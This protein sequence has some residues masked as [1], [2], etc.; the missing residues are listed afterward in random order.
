MTH[1]TRVKNGVHGLLKGAAA[2]LVG[3]VFACALLL[4][5]TNAAPQHESRVLFISSYSLAFPAVPEQIEGLRAALPDSASLDYLFMDTKAL[6]DEAS[7]AQF[8]EVCRNKLLKSGPYDV[9]VLGDDAALQFAHAHEHTLFEDVPLVFEGVNNIELAR[10]AVRSPLITGVS[11]EPQYEENIR[12]ALR[13]YPAAKNIVAIVDSTETGVGEQA[14]FM[15]QAEKFPQL[16]FSVLNSSL[17]TQSAFCTA[18]SSIRSDTLL[19]SFS[20]NDN[21]SGK[22]YSLAEQMSMIR[23]FTHVPVFRLSSTGMGE[24]YLGGKM[25][26]FVELG[27]LAGVLAT[28]ILNGADP[29][30]LPLITQAPAKFVYDYA[31]L[32][33]YGIQKSDVA[34]NAVF[35]NLPVSFWSQYRPVIVPGLLILLAFTGGLAYTVYDSFRYRSM[36]KALRVATADLAYAAHFDTLTGT[37]RRNYF[38][39]CAE[40]LIHSSADTQFVFFRTDIYRFRAVNELYGSARGDEVLVAFGRQL[41]KYTDDKGGLCARF[42]ADNFVGCVPLTDFDAPHF[43]SV[44]NDGIRGFIPGHEIVV[45]LGLYAVE[46][47]ALPILLMCDR[48][49]TALHSIKGSILRRFAWY[50]ASLRGSMLLEQQIINEMDSALSGGEFKVYYQ[51]IYDLVT[52]K[53]VSAEALSRWCHPTLGMISPAIF[54]PVLERNG[55]IPRLDFF[56]CEQVCRLQGRL[57]AEQ[58]TMVPISL[59][60][61]RADF[62]TDNLS[63]TIPVLAKRWGVPAGMLK[64]EVTETAYTDDPRQLVETTSC[65]REQGFP[66]LMDDFGSGYSSLNALK[67]IPM[68]IL[69]LDICFLQEFNKS[70]RAASIMASVVSMAK[71]LDMYVIA[72]GVETAEQVAFL[73]SIGCDAAQGYY[74]ARPMPEDAFCTLLQTE[75]S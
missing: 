41:R 30:S 45:R 16:H 20:M 60:L 49:N 39:E 3:L 40:K 69:K 58:G 36:T 47:A 28:R 62:G 50:D 32:Q 67:D 35:L 38:L 22:V 74:Y 24:G 48:A 65:L 12:T 70:D 51:P 10:R 5:G 19:F 59:N 27:R 29:A 4:P 44:L 11:E 56:V 71:L 73:R 54:I 1:Q 6:R 43:L 55:F 8:Y 66:V 25:I 61:S 68:D 13:L 2:A 33:Q 15:A 42:Q 57:S 26:S 14:Q 21:A 46:D 23:E 9:V 64:L 34:A 17:L 31:V 75:L 7:Y 37:Y 52:E 63:Q 53:P 72:E 18:L